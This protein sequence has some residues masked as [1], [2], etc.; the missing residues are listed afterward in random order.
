[1]DKKYFPHSFGFQGH[2]NGNKLI[3]LARDDQDD[4]P[5]SF[6]LSKAKLIVD[7]IDFIKKYIED[8]DKK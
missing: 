4:Y 5:F 8:N 3:K 1:M 6:G 7:N 2:Y